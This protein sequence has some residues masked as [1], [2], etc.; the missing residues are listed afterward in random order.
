[1]DVTSGANG[2]TVTVRTTLAVQRIGRCGIGSGSCVKFEDS[3][4]LGR[5]VQCGMS[6]LLSAE[7]VVALAAAVASR[8]RAWERMMIGLRTL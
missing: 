2:L 8:S 3:Y 7:A 4:W 1:V 6:Y 5:C